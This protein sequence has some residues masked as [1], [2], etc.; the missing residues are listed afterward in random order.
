MTTKKIHQ[1]WFGDSNRTPFKIMESWKR[2]CSKFG[3]EYCFWTER[4]VESLKMLNRPIYDY[5]KNG[6]DGVLGHPHYHGMSNI[7]RL[8]IINQFGGYYFDCD[9]YSWETDIE[10][11]V[12]LNHDMAIFTPENLFPINNTLEKCNIWLVP[13]FGYVDSAYFLSNGVFYANPDNNILSFMINNLMEVLLKHKEMTYNG[14]PL[15]VSSVKTCG[16]WQLSNFA[17]RHPF[18]MLSPKFVFSDVSYV[19][20]NDSVNFS[21]TPA[22]YKSQ[23]ISSYIANHDCNR[24]SNIQ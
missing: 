6:C 17:K 23:I 1:I 5:Y 4:E 11:I 9:F 14:L 15:S 13:F 10:S 24:I 2:Y 18:V 3:W 22:E 16:C 19:L 21:G 8:E 12:N 20:N 7:A